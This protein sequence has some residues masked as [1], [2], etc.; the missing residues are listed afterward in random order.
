[1]LLPPAKLDEPATRAALEA[2]LARAASK[3]LDYPPGAALPEI[4]FDALVGEVAAIAPAFEFE[5]PPYFL[6]NA[7]ALASLEGLARAADP[8]FS[9][10]E[11]IYP[12]ALT[13]ILAG[14]ASPL[15]RRTLDDLATDPA[16]GRLSVRK[17][18]SLVDQLAAL[19]RKPRLAVTLDVVRTRGG[20]R[21]IRRLARQALRGRG[22]AK[23]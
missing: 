5:L 1:M 20:R 11:S 22:S 10:V 13:T 15:M 3:L 16:T 2:A 4:R 19:S 7:R 8:T 12:F 21:V 17:L 23:T 18:R 14:D 9:I 6:N